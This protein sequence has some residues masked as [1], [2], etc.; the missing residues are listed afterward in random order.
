MIQQ[1]LRVCEFVFLNIQIVTGSKES[2]FKLIGDFSESIKDVIVWDKGVGEPAMNSNVINRGSELILCLE[3]RPTVGRAFSRTNFSRGTMP[4]IWRLGKGRS[5]TKDHN[6]S[7]PISLPSKIISGWSIEGN[8]ILDPFCGTGTT[9]QAAKNLNRFAIGIEIE[10]KYC[11]IA[12][13][14]LQQEVLQF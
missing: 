8:M 3:S 14:R 2:W 4:D 6:A 13:K 7:F 1:S 12:V 11:E 9:L 10:E 5:I